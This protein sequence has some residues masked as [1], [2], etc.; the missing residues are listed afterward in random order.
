M[1]GLARGG[2]AWV[3]WGL[4]AIVLLIGVVLLACGYQRFDS[5]R[6]LP[7]EATRIADATTVTGFSRTAITSYTDDDRS[8]AHVYFIGPAPKPDPVAVASVPTIQLNGVTPPSSPPGVDSR[9]GVVAKGKRSDGCAASVSYPANL[10]LDAR[11][12][13]F[14]LSAEQL[15]TVFK[16]EQVVIDVNIGNC[17]K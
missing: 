15:A 14:H 7:A 17:G 12:S 5:W 11:R 2:R 16:G 3:R 6:R 8:F 1:R 9:V 10:D 4:S 13:Q